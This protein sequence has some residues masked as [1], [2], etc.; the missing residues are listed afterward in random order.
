V[1]TGGTQQF[2][3]TVT[4]SSDTSV[5]WSVDGVAGGNS[6][7][8]T[9]SS[10]GFYTAPGT[11]GIHT[12][13]VTSIADS[14]K[15]ASATV[16]VTSTTSGSCTPSGGQPSVTICNPASGPMASS[17]VEISA[18]STSSPVATLI[19]VYLDGVKVFQRH[20]SSLDTFL[21]MSNG[22]HRLTVQAFNGTW[23][24]R[25]EFITVATPTRLLY[26]SS[27]SW[28]G[29]GTSPIFGVRVN[30]DGSL[31]SLDTA[32]QTSNQFVVLADVTGHH[33]FGFDI[34]STQGSP[35]LL[36]TFA[37]QPDTGALQQ[38]SSVALPPNN[39]NVAP[40]MT[41]NA[42]GTLLFVQSSGVIATYSVDTAGNLTLVHA[43]DVGFSGNPVVPVVNPAGTFLYVAATTSLG[44]TTL[45]QFAI[46]SSGALTQVSSLAVGQ[47]GDPTNLVITPN[48]STVYLPIGPGAGLP[49]VLTFSVDPSTG[50]LTQGATVNCNC[51]NGLPD[52]GGAIA[53]NAQGTLLFQ[54]TF[55][56]T[57][58]AGGIALYA[59]ESTGALIPLPNS[60]IG[61]GNPGGESF[62]LDSSGTSLY[63]TGC[64]PA[65]QLPCGNAQ[66]QGFFV[67]GNGAVTLAPGSVGSL[68]PF[69][70]LTLTMVN[71]KR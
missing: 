9:I 30:N 1:A 8:G 26:G 51:D 33:L 24:K 2:T 15:S 13:T 53:V 60:F 29:G 61:V 16:T 6:T 23:F 34:G 55:G 58:G 31:T 42:A 11:A 14:T 57:V 47:V 4:G 39:L 69:G 54:A 66:I 46:D 36:A 22:T 37:V 5:T 18:A 52:G 27:P 28:S 50:K 10:S 64:F 63:T 49:G 3:D 43:A 7:V 32:L 67:S 48:G 62:V 56:E 17:P 71:F 41:L 25:T 20:A 45:E 70:G 19:Q 68:F 65:S 35:G 59:I 40:A 21:N 12:V 38:S 44:D